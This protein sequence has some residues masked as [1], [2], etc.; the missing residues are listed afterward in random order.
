[1][2]PV[3]RLLRS[4]RNRR[5]IRLAQPPHKLVLLAA[6]SCCWAAAVV[7]PISAAEAWALASNGASRAR[8]VL[9][10]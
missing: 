10:R 8:R 2:Q 5:G 6:L 3:Q 1:M 7:A 4:G 9:D